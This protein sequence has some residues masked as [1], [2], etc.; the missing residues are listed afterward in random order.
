MSWSLRKAE[1][2]VVSGEP[3]RHSY[4]E[5]APLTKDAKY[6]NRYPGIQ[7]DIESY[8]Y[9]PLLEA[10]GYCPT[11]KYS[12][13][14]E[15]QR[16][17]S[18]IAK[19]YDLYSK[20]LLQTEAQDMRW[21]EV[22][23]TWDISTT[24]G[25]K[26]TAKWLIPATG[27]FDTPKFP[28]IPGIET[29]KGKQ[30]HTSRWDYDYTGGD[31]RGNLTKLVDKRVGIIGTGAT[32]VQIMPHLGA[33][34]GELFV[35]QRTPSSIDIRGNKP[36][37]EEWFKSQ[38]SGWQRTRMDNFAAIVTGDPTEGDL[39]NDGWTKT[40]TQLGGWFGTGGD[41]TAES[42]EKRLQTNDY[43]KMES[44]R[45]RI[46]Q[47]VKDPKTAEALKPY[48]NAFCKR[49]CFHDD[50]LPTFN[51]KN[52]TLVDTSGKGVDC[53]TERGI[54]ANGKEY[55]LDV[56]IYSTG[57]EFST[58]W[59]QRHHHANVFGNDGKNIS[60]E[61]HEGPVTYHGW[62]VRGFP[63]AFFI[64]PS[65]TSG[66]PNYGHSL[67]DQ[68]SHLLY[69]M[70]KCKRDGIDRLECSAEAQE[71]WVAEVIEKGKGRHK[72]LNFCTPGYYN[73]E[74]KVGDFTSKHSPYGGSPT[75]FLEMVRRWRKAD[76]L[77][78]LE[79]HHQE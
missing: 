56:I 1:I 66:L 74:G 16:Y 20:S 44:I 30:F 36:T 43:R 58:D 37:D 5:V 22:S 59:K 7:I 26:I 4:V 15:I 6:W 63:N 62:S 70:D 71:K 2:L 18:L 77:E 12:P 23:K 53:I 78:G 67:E 17:L 64:S 52:V 35:F 57:F 25:D 51:R 76:T 49:P 54:V 75:G 68:T 60:D 65:Q 41:G 31:S 28:G 38:P 55:E 13:G 79:V 47:V 10:T 73:D 69:L 45:M 27:P 40:V 14:E 48:F 24:R 46:G 61:W 33:W 11:M 32:A 3:F 29:F 72:F 19:K 8:I 39:V 42:E 34:S 50:Y 9:M 21:N